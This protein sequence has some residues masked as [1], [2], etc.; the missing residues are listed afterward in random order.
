MPRWSWLLVLSL[1][2]QSL[3]GAGDHS[4]AGHAWAS[5]QR[6]ENREPVVAAPKHLDLP[7]MWA[8]ALEHNS[9]LREAAADIDAARGQMRQAGAYP[10][11]RFSYQEEVIGSRIAP[12]G[13][14]ALA[15]HQE[16]VTG[17]KRRLDQAIAAHGVD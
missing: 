2:C 16:V 5:P 12:Q 6:T 9:E 10:N 3:P 1:G 13:N 8:L 11:P 7:G 17:G 4:G 14:I 15:L